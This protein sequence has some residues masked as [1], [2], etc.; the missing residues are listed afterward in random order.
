VRSHPPRAHG[1]R[2]RA[3]IPLLVVLVG[4]M[5]GAGGLLLLRPF[6][7]PGTL[8]PSGAPGASGPSR[9]AAAGQVV[10][11]TLNDQAVYERLKPAVVDVTST[12]GYDNETASG[13]GFIVD[14]RSALVLTNN[15]VI[16]D[17]T[18]VTATL[19][20]TGRTYPARIVGADVDADIAVLQLRGPAGLTAVPLGDSAAVTLGMP[21]LAIGNQA[22][23]DGSPTVASG[24]VNSLNRTIEADDAS[25]G[26]TETL[27]GMLQTSARIA[28]GDSGGPLAD[29]AGEVIG[30]DTATGT[31]TSG[32]GYAIPINTAMAVERQIAAGRAGPGITIGVGGFLGVVVA[33][34]ASTS[35]RTQATEGQRRT[36]R[37][38]SAGPHGCLI[39]EAGAG[40][41]AVVA[42]APW[43][44]L[45]DGVLCGTGA[46][47]AGIAA[48]DVITAAA[49]RRVPDAAALT[50]IVN[51]LLPATVVLVTW[52]N[53]AGTTRAALVRVGVAPA[54]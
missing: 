46:A 20:S 9:P 35:P 43:G 45:V 44:A 27:R 28:P 8:R 42:P 24:I 3:L 10:A 6:G 48:G 33:S 39:T 15:H 30:V 52:V 13:T 53:T 16:R 4:V 25:T 32:A 23:K 54:V 37:A 17:A 34:T 51:S 14:G 47:A 19:T 40:M 11:G 1:P 38:A 36:D 41:P 5:L 29:A 21:V 22:G 12:L 18:S 7:T 26:F 50:A 31:G 2:D 49:G